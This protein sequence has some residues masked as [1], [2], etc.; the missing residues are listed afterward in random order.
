MRFVAIVQLRQVYKYAFYRVCKDT[1]GHVHEFTAAAV[2]HGNASSTDSAAVGKGRHVTISLRDN[3]LDSEAIHQ[4][5]LMYRLQRQGAGGSGGGGSGCWMNVDLRDNR[6]TRLLDDKAFAALV[7]YG[8][9]NLYPV[10]TIKQISSNHH[11]SIE[12]T[13]SKHRANVKQT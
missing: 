12:Q 4:T 13:S 8:Q 2:A 9:K 11:A 10:Y 1:P 7:K 3:Q 6:I 5:I